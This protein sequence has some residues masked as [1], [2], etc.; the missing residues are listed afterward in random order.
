MPGIEDLARFLSESDRRLLK[1]LRPSPTRLLYRLGYP[2]DESESRDA[3]KE[4]LFSE[5]DIRWDGKFKWDGTIYWRTL[6]EK[7]LPAVDLV[8]D[9]SV[10]RD[11]YRT[12]LIAKADALWNGSWKW[13]GTLCWFPP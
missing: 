2:V 10:V 8:E 1:A 5:T 4:N 11:G 12:L 9:S 6:I 3:K 7:L 13:D